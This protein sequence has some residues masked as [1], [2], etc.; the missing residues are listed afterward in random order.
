MIPLIVIAG[1]T[2][3][4]KTALAVKIAKETGS[5]I[6]SADSMQIYKKMDIGTAK[7]TEEEMEGIPH[8][9]IDYVD[10]ALNYS[11]S[12]YVSDAKKALADI[13]ERGEIPIL[14]GGTGLYIDH[15]VYDIMLSDAPSDSLL[16]KNLTDE[17]AKKGGE[18]MLSKLYEIDPPAAEKLH[19]ND[20]KRIV[21][22]LEIYLLTGRTK[23]EW[24]RASKQH[25]KTYDFFYFAI[26]TP[27]KILYNN[28]NARADKMVR[29]GLFDE[30]RALFE[31]IPPDG[32]AAQG[33]GYREAGYYLRGLSTRDET[34]RLIK[35][36]TRR[37]AKRQLTWF[38]K[39]PDIVW[40][41]PEDTKKCLHMIKERWG[42]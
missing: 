42:I 17:A 19:P 8:H 27:R 35:R 38:G 29:A 14:A 30:A 36:N 6:V 25:E 24:D 22:A 5:E 28:I 12:D 4:G 1:P 34:I 3:S 39:N 33:I 23:T 10:P 31:Y 7:P 20:I 13:W 26:E 9:L 32:T 41:G 18:Y 11:L 21:R 15:V 16:R 37:L 40:I 2:A